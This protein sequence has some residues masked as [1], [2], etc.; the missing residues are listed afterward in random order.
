MASARLLAI[1]CWTALIRASLG[2]SVLPLS[3]K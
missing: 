2:D 3:R 1:H